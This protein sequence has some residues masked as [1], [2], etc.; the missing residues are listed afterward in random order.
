MTRTIAL[1]TLLS[2]GCAS[3]AVETYTGPDRG[4]YMLMPATDHGL[5]ATVRDALAKISEKCDGLYEVTSFGAV[6]DT[7]HRATYHPFLDRDGTLLHGFFFNTFDYQ[8]RPPQSTQLNDFLAAVARQAPPA[9]YGCLVTYD[10]PTGRIC[11]P[12]QAACDGR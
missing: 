5:P 2:T 12:T 6:P 1:L 3:I 11:A 10:C 7:G 9:D 8:C 4:Q